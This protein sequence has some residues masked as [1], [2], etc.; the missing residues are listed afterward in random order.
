M[1]PVKQKLYTRQLCF[2]LF[3]YGS[4]SKLLLY[5]TNLS[6]AV[7]RDLWLPVV[8]QWLFSTLCVWLV[9]FV[10]SRTNKTFFELLQAKVGHI[11][12]RIVMGSFALYF[13][14]ATVMPLNEQKLF[15]QN[16]FYD[17]LPSLLAVLP[18]FFYLVFVGCRPFNGLGRCADVVFFIYLVAVCFLLVMAMGEVR[19]DYFLPVLHTPFGK[20]TQSVW[21]QLYHFPEGAWLLFFMG[22]IDY[23][24]GDCARMTLSYLAGGVVVLLVVLCFW[25]IYSY[26]APNQFFALTKIALFFSAMNM[27]GRVDYTLVYALDLV[28]LFCLSIN[29]RLGIYAMQKAT[30]VKNVRI[31]SLIFNGIL[32]V[33]VFVFNYHFSSL[34]KFYSQIAPFIYLS[35]TF[36]PS[37]IMFVAEV[38]FKSHPQLLTPKRS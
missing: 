7:G 36:L 17:T 29:V 10:M 16:I 5:P 11:P 32:C 28:M 34:Q 15:V 27:M 13:L 30:G 4:I 31:L 20:L 19:L 22:R 24:K 18:V 25:G 2:M 21:S 8:L 14:F 26:L 12:A 37:L 1:N 33:S 3:A 35:F 23:K 9:A 6:Y 38:C